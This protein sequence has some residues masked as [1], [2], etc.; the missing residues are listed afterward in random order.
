MKSASL[1]VLFLVFAAGSIS[2]QT[3]QTMFCSRHPLRIF[4]DHSTVNLTPLFQWW[5][6]HERATRTDPVRPLAAWQRITG[7]KV[8]DL[9]FNWVVDAVIYTSPSTRTNARIILKNPPVAE[10]QAFYNLKAQLAEAGPRI[11]NDQRA[12]QAN[13]KAAQKAES[14]A[15]ADQRSRNARTRVNGNNYSQQAEQERAAAAAALN[16]QKEVEQARALAEKQLAAIPTVNGK[17]QID[18]FGMEI[19]RNKQGQLIYDLGV[20]D[21]NSP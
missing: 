8:A 4:G 21:A 7:T 14:R 6:R 3:N 17:Y 18:W 13:T 9:E 20:L 16:D 19:G 1:I 15:Q 10:E 12:S 2:A 11:A 5:T